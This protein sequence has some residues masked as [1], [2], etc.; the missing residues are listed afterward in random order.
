[1]KLPF[2]GAAFNLTRNNS[3]H[4]VKFYCNEFY[5]A[6]AAELQD[7]YNDYFMRFKNL[8]RP[9]RS[10]AKRPNNNSLQKSMDDNL[11]HGFYFPEISLF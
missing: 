2:D 3:F 8:K 5:P 10:N 9:S 4:L 11:Q 7:Q 1:M 6:I